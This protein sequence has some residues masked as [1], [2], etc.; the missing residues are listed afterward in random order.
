M[1]HSIHQIT[2]TFP[3]GKFKGRGSFG[4][5]YGPFSN[6]GVIAYLQWLFPQ[7]RKPS[8]SE[9]D[10]YIFKL[11]N[12]DNVSTKF[13]SIYAKMY[14]LRQALIDDLDTRMRQHFVYI[15]YLGPV[16]DGILEIQPY[17]GIP[18]RLAL[19]KNMV[20][21]DQIHSSF[22]AILGG[23]YRICKNKNL[24]VTDIKPENMVYNEAKGI[25]SLIDLEYVDLTNTKDN[26]VYTNMYDLLPIQVFFLPYF[27]QQPPRIEKYKATA[28]DREIIPLA[29]RKMIGEFSLAWAIVH[30]YF[31]IIK[32]HFTTSSFL[33]PLKEIID[34]MTEKRWSFTVP[35][36][37]R[38][39]RKMN[40]SF[41]GNDHS[42][43]RKYSK[44]FSNP[45]TI[46]V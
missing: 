45:R 3:K 19:K 42:S 16:S 36:I 14:K 46:S 32:K 34:E 9:S 25:I 2:S 21:M 33:P 22:M 27:N 17:G 41:G 1:S 37:L 40:K 6:L 35:E 5:V 24:L 39:L 30:I 18:L 7:G 28:G 20:P 29:Y 15:L 44:V 43:E 23:L 13:P 26:L 38:K 12:M 8:L 4:S 31:K 10:E 11:I